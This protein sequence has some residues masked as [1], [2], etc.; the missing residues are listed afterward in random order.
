MTPLDQAWKQFLTTPLFGITLTV[1]V[2]AL[3]VR[4]WRRCGSNALLTPVLTAMLAIV[5]L[6]RIT[7][8]SYATYMVGGNYL[9]FL[10][11]P[12][13]VALAVPLYHAA[14]QIRRFWMPVS[15]GVLAGSTVAMASGI[16]TVRVLGGDHVLEATMAPKSATTPIAIAMSASA[17]GNTSLTAVLT[18]LTGVLGAIAGPALLNLLRIHDPRV[19]GLAMGVSSHGI[20]TSRALAQGPVNGAFS[21]LAMASSGVVTSLLAPAVLLLLGGA[22]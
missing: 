14:E 12:A 3:A 6:L 8:I 15:I 21:A 18:V 4:L 2:Y 20:G 10:L 13:T 5:A 1:L 9:A 19:L 17:G 11:G 16:L 22:S 7:H